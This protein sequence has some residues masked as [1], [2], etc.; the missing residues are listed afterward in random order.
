MSQ[1]HELHELSHL[2]KK[3]KPMSDEANVQELLKLLRSM[4]AKIN[5][6]HA[7]LGAQKQAPVKQLQRHR[8]DQPI[9]KIMSDG[10]MWA[11]PAIAEEIIARGFG[12]RHPSV[13]STKLNKMARAGTIEKVAL[14]VYRLPKKEV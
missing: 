5:D 10:K 1:K 2:I 8:L 3:E 9:L 7:H 12:D 6:I 11:Q 13:L 4:N 14:G